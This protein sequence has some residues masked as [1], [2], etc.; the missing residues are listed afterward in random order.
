MLFC[1]LNG[2]VGVGVTSAEP[3]FLEQPGFGVVALALYQASLSYW[4]RQCLL[5]VLILG[6]ENWPQS[7][8]L[9][10]V[11]PLLLTCSRPWRR[12]WSPLRLDWIAYTKYVQFHNPCLLNSKI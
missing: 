7:G 10:S 4:D 2:R 1:D 9:A 5:R 8:R 3:L 12:L 11:Q 6:G